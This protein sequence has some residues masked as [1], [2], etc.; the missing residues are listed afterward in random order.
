MSCEE[1][2]LNSDRGI[3]NLKNWICNTT[4]QRILHCTCTLFENKW[5]LVVYINKCNTITA[6]TSLDVTIL[7]CTF[8]DLLSTLFKLDNIT[9]QKPTDFNIVGK[10]T[11]HCN[12]WNTL[13]FINISHSRNTWNMLSF[14]VTSVMSI[15][16]ERWTLKS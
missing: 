7:F 10:I 11:F 4:L 3:Y 8:P 5:C 16:V 1:R 6:A 2:S 15:A 13:R 14:R 9:P 12:H